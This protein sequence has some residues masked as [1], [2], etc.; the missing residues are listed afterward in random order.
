MLD[1]FGH[2]I[3]QYLYGN[4]FDI[5]RLRNIDI[6]MIITVYGTV[7]IVE[8]YEPVSVSALNLGVLISF[9]EIRS[10][11][12]GLWNHSNIM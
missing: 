4:L 11:S 5:Y 7:L 10:S 6:A 12:I 9:L 8:A 2:S 1:P 3:L